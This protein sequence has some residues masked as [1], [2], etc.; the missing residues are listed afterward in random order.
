MKVEV[1][2]VKVSNFPTLCDLLKPRVVS[3]LEDTPSLSRHV[4]TLLLCSLKQTT[5]RMIRTFNPCLS[6]GMQL[7]AVME[8]V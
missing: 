7:H 3:G 6:N 1:I 8:F 4:A 5:N 2:N